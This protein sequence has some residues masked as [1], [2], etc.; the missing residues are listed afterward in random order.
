MIIFSALY[1]LL[2]L[3]TNMVHAVT[4]AFFQALNY[5]DYMFGVSFACMALT[6]FLTSPFWGVYASRIGYV[7]CFM[8]GTW[9]M[10]QGR[11]C[12]RLP[13]RL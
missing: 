4:P 6:N 12:L 13:S 5:P 2:Y 7:R 8:F 9:A 11:S 1:G 10:W 3:G